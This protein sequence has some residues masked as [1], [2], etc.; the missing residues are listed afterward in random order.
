MSPTSRTQPRVRASELVGRGWLNTGGRE[1]TLGDLRGK[2]V[3]LDFW[4]FCCINCLHVIDELRG[5]EERYHDV[6]VTIGVHSPKFVHEADPDALAAAVERYDVAH[7][8]LDDPELTTWKAYTARAWPTLVLIDPEGYIVGHM[9]G[10]GHT[11]NIAVAVEQ[12]VAEHEA[13]GTLHRGSGPYVPPEPTSGLLRFPAKALALPTGN[14]LVADAGHHRLVELAPDGETLV[15]TIGSGERGRDDGAADSASLSEPNGLCLL[16]PEVA[17]QVG[18]DVV[19]ADTVNHLL[20]GVHLGSGTVTTLAGTGEQ[21]MVGAPNNVLPGEEPATEDYG[22]GRRIRLSSPWDVAWSAEARAVV[23]AMAGHHT[24]WTFDPADGHLARLGGTMNE[25]LV[26]GE[27][28]Q[29][30]FAQPSGLSVG[31]DGRVWLADSETSALRYVDVPGAQ[32]RTVVGQ[33]LFDFGHRDGPAAQALLQHPLG[34]AALAD[35][36]VAVADTYNG[37]VRLYDPATGEVSTVATG[38][39][40]PSGLLVDDDGAHL[41]VVESA[42]H[43]LTRVPVPDGAAHRH[44]GGAHR[45]HRPVTEVAPRFTLRVVFTP[46]AGQKLDDRFGPSTQLSVSADALV[47]GGGTGTE[48]ERQVTL[49]LGSLGAEDD[50]RTVLSVT[51]KAASCDADSG[52]EFP[53]CHLA[54]QD[55]GIPVRVVEGGPEELVLNL[56]G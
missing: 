50:G 36:R 55:W 26:D 33:G 32:V 21:F 37:A 18:Y 19:V 28:R 23:V 35:G 12:L 24:L 38:L 11:P 48:L 3:L 29:A 30:W 2:I 20:R 1:L 46:P 22:P 9:A 47:A 16:P 42:A 25:G 53:A 31:E 17:Q 34:V 14:L 7:P 45:T 39:A 51:A 27:L 5:L 44:D 43:R 41:V 15:R 4:T 54:A 40:E 49:G 8:V 56:H 6:L 13:R 10:E 52:V